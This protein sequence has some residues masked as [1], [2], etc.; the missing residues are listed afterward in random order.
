M[1]HET[2]KPVDLM[3]YL[4]RT[5]SNPGD[6]VL[7]STMG[8]GST[9]VAAVQCQRKFIGIENDPKYFEIAKS[10]VRKATKQTAASAQ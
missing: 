10:R 1:V 9:G 5:Y 3:A 4:V 8:S 2:Q 6:T 7:D